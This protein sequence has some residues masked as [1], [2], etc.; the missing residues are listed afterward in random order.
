MSLFEQ[1]SDYAD[2]YGNDVIWKFRDLEVHSEITDHTRWSVVHFAVFKR[3]D[4][5][6]GV[7]YETAATEYQDDEEFFPEV[8]AVT[9][10]EKVI[11]VYRRVTA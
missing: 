10:E 3:D 2:D 6:V 1:M 4:E 11:T 5:F 8:F 9:P 7:E